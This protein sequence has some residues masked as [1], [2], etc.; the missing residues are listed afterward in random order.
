M[1]ACGGAD[2]DTEQIIKHLK[3]NQSEEIIENIFLC[4]IFPKKCIRINHKQSRWFDLVVETNL[5]NVQNINRLMSNYAT[6]YLLYSSIL[7]DD[8]KDIIRNNKNPIICDS[9]N[10]LKNMRKVK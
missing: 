7:T 3:Q 1:T 2:P 4:P 8:C 9:R 10:N 5:I 6:E